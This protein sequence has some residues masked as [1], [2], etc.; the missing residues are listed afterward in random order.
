MSPPRPPGVD[1]PKHQK[2]NRDKTRADVMFLDFLHRLNM[3]ASESGGKLS[4][5]PAYRRG[6]LVNAVDLLKPHLPVGV[7]PDNFP[8]SAFK[9]TKGAAL[10]VPIPEIDF[11]S[12]EPPA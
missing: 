5:D 2:S 1:P 7:V 6:T 10:V 9:K 4:V 11:Y 3:V 12:R 8:F